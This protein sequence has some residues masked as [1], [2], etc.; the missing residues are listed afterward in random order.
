MTFKS[1]TEGTPD[2]NSKYCTVLRRVRTVPVDLEI[3][4]PDSN[5]PGHCSLSFG[6]SAP[7]LFTSTHRAQS[8]P[9]PTTQPNPTTCLPSRHLRSAHH[10]H[11]CEP[12]LTLALHLQSPCRQPSVISLS[13]L[14]LHTPPLINNPFAPQRAR[15]SNKPPKTTR[16]RRRDIR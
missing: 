6:A 10:S 11:A 5:S 1:P 3:A 7:L 2:R 16:G 13:P 12:I 8:N 9:N 14:T 4:F 15:P